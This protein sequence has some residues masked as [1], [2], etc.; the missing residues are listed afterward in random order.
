MKRRNLTALLLASLAG[1]IVPAAAQMPSL[2]SGAG[3]M[4]GGTPDLSSMSAGNAAGVLEYC[5]KNKLLGGTDATSVLGGLTEKP[6]VKESDDYKLG[7][8]GSLQ[9]SGKSPLSLDSVPPKM[10]TK[11]CDMVLKH[12][13]SLI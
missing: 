3:G 8:A 5:M 2:P 7:E 9:T 10:K 6:E 11:A 1:G 12:A 13:K 4:L